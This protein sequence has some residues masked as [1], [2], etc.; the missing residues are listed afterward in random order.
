MIALLTIDGRT[1]QVM[2]SSLKRSFRLQEG[3]NACDM[4]DG[5]HIRDL[6]GVYIDY[7]ME[8]DPDYARTADY[9]TLYEILSA[10]VDSHTV[11]LPYGRNSTITYQAQITGGD[12]ALIASDGK[13]DAL[14]G[15]L[16]VLFKAKQPQK[17]PEDD[18]TT[19][20]KVSLLKDPNSTHTNQSI[21]VA[22]LLGSV[23]VS[24]SWGSSAYSMPVIVGETL[25]FTLVDM[26]GA[27]IE[28]M[29]GMDGGTVIA[30]NPKITF[31]E[32]VSETPPE[33]DDPPA[34]W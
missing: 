7:T 17:V 13:S 2:V 26:D 25:T 3:R 11:T 30:L 20:L 29:T 34:S 9:D 23:D 18:V 33:V 21:H 8:I 15:G 4:Q 16:T 31:M 14:W 12:D 32:L 10:P 5:S 24:G 6:V 27:T 1:F 28:S 19:T 22:G